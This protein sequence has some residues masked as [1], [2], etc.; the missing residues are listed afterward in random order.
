MLRK[1]V[2]VGIILL[3]ISVAL[4][5]N[6]NADVNISILNNEVVE[7][8]TEYWGVGE[9][10]HHS[11][12][13]TKQEALEVESIYNKLQKKLE[14]IAIED[15]TTIIFND[16]IVELEKYGLLGDLS[17]KEAQKLVSGLHQNYRGKNIF[18]K[19][20]EKFE[21]NDI[22]ALS[23]TNIFCSIAFSATNINFQKGWILDMLLSILRNFILMPSGVLS[24][25]HIHWRELVYFGYYE[26]WF[27]KAY[28]AYGWLWTD[29]LLGEKNWSGNFMGDLSPNP[30]ITRG[31]L[32][33][34]GMTIN[35]PN[36]SFHMGFAKLV[37]IRKLD[38]IG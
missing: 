34:T 24:L 9:V 37:K 27:P 12:I 33:F 1:S 38:Y 17:I 21:M 23:N 4:A 3:F 25:N 14:D 36:E 8:N 15:E 22:E 16:A 19:V 5:P 32:G 6:I 35:N 2:S 29:G 11:I 31:V 26:G 7:F 28:P 10:K 18:D 20:E 30:L 13:L